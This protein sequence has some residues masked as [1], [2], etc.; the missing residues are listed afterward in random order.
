MM[1]T[2]W[3]IVLT[4]LMFV[5]GGAQGSAGTAATIEP[6]YLIDVPTAGIIPGG[7]FSLDMDFYQSGGVLV[8]ASI[9][10][11]SRMLFGIY[12]GGAGI[13][14]SEPPVWNPSPGFVIKLRII[15]ETL[16]LPAIALGFDSQGKEIYLTD[17]SRYTIKSPGFY[18]VLSKNYSVAGYLSMHGGINYSLER[19][20]GDSD[21]NLF[22]GIEKSIGPVA[23]VLAE[24]NLGANDSNHDARG[25]GRGYLNIGFHFSIGK[26][27]T[28]GIHFKDL[29]R[30]QQDVTIGNRTLLLEYVQSF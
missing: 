12:Y 3:C 7:T 14:G 17:L 29:F 30:N 23:S 24:Y 8:G 21:P 25:R 28:L 19:A 10:A 15:D 22:A 20:D 11:L 16:I 26:G 4:L 13:I 2:L 5:H 27:F 9:G 6:R 18:A 1:R